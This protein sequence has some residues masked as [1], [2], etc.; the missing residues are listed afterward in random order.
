MTATIYHETYM[1]CLLTR[2]ASFSGIKYRG[3]GCPDA[4][5]VIE[6]VTRSG[7]RLG[8]VECAPHELVSMNSLVE[9]SCLRCGILGF[10]LNVGQT[11]D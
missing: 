5:D 11:C 2:S 7:R 10:D 4:V 1:L 6:G 8:G 9:G 3:G